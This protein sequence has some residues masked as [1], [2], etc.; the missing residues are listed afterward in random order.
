ML[1]EML[2]ARA[3]TLYAVAAQSHSELVTP[4]VLAI[5]DGAT[6]AYTSTFPLGAAIG[7]VVP[8]CFVAIP[9][10]GCVVCGALPC[11]VV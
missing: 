8:A 3:A 9:S 4:Q 6:G 5:M 2:L 11:A 10:G 7:N 1:T